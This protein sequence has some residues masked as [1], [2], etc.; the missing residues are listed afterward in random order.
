LETLSI[1]ARVINSISH[2]EPGTWWFLYFQSGSWTAEGR[3]LQS[4][5]H[6]ALWSF[7]TTYTDRRWWFLRAWFVV[8]TYNW[9]TLSRATGLVPGRSRSTPSECPNAWRI[10]PD[11]PA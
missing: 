3:A 2:G 8:T 9:S 5:L 7:I 6:R 1:T 4:A 11:L 10:V